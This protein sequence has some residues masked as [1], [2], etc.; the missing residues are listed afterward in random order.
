MKKII[1]TVAAATLLLGGA[2]AANA[3]TSYGNASAIPYS[4][5]YVALYTGRSASLGRFTKT[6]DGNFN[7]TRSLLEGTASGDGSGPDAGSPNGG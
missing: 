6:P 4:A 5:D 1:T 2:A 7:S 3:A